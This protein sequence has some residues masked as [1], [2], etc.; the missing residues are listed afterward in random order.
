MKSQRPVKCDKC[1]KGFFLRSEDIK[2]ANIEIKGQKLVISFFVC[3]RCNAVY[4]IL[5]KDSMLISLMNDFQL[6][7][8]RAARLLSKGE[9]DKA[10]DMQVRASKK[11]HRAKAYSEKLSK[12]FTG[13]F[14][15]SNNIITYHE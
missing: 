3:P 15:M 14:E 9:E 5:I 4:K 12:M 8:Q 11:H 13:E 7:Q 1:N 6:T 10:R 2:E